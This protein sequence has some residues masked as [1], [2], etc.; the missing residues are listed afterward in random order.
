MKQLRYIKKLVE[1]TGNDTAGYWNQKIVLLD[2]VCRDLGG[3]ISDE[4]VRNIS[5]NRDFEWDDFL[6]EYRDRKVII[7]HITIS[8]L[9]RDRTKSLEKI[10]R[11]VKVFEESGDKVC[12][13]ILPQKQILT[14]L[15][16]IDEDLW[17]RFNQL[18]Q[19]IK[20]TKNCIYDHEGISLEF[21]HRWN[22]YYGD[23][24]PIVR[25]CVLKKIPVM[26]E[27]IDV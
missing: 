19:K 3:L 20:N 13:V 4:N 8:F 16:G 6:G 17:N 27:N 24:D 15:P 5:E 12:A 7:Y 10:E 23:A 9:L 14:D 1:L 18:V 21:M 22:G 25:K 11:S 2:A 26:I